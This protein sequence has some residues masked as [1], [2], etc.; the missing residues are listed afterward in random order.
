MTGNFVNSSTARAIFAIVYSDSGSDVYYTISLP[1]SDE[2]KLSA[3]ISGLPSG[4]YNVSVFVVAD[5]GLPFPRSATT[6]RSVSVMEGAHGKLLCV[7]TCNYK[8][9]LVHVLGESVYTSEFQWLSN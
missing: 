3:S 6:P 5:D 2:E 8:G 7:C 4:L 1:S 9:N